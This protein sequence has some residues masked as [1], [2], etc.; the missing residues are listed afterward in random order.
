MRDIIVVTIV[1]IA[2]IAALRRPWV[3][4]MLWN[5]LSIMNPHRYAWGFAYSAPLAALA[6]GS[7][8]VGLMLTPYRQSPFQGRPVWWLAAFSVWMTLTW[9]LG[10]DPSGDYPQWDK[11]M[12]IYLMTF[13]ALALLVDEYRLRIFAWVT[14][15]SVAVLAAKGGFFTLLTA[16]SY[17]VWG[18]P[19]SAIADNNEFAL[20]T[21]I[22]VPIVYFL[23]VSYS[24][25]W[26]RYALIVIIA[27]MVVSAL[28]SHSRGGLLALL[29]MSA[30]LWWRSPNKIALALVLAVFVA[31]YVPFLPDHWWDRMETIQNYEEDASAMGRINAWVVAWETAKSSPIRCRHVLSARGALP[32]I[33]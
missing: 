12:K 23:Y 13:V 24:Q 10:L 33:R 27:L 26:V 19:G 30:F 28:G 15:G 22:T 20:A 6:A 32:G 11:V 14:A 29:A 2:A 21:I 1:L 25:R 8:I 7:T 17:R 9:A 3:G 4:V 5:W 31:V 16:G 18:P